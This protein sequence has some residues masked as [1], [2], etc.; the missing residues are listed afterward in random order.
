M[1]QLL[2][3]AFLFLIFCPSDS[4]K[5]K[6]FVVEVGRY[7]KPDFATNEIRCLGAV[8]GVRHVLTVAEC[9]ALYGD[10]IENQEITV[11]EKVGSWRKD[12]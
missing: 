11:S 8:I 5:P 12:I 1:K 2:F 3:S 6:K 9:V 7:T 10:D 4:L